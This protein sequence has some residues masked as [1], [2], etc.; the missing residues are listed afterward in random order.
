MFDNIVAYNQGNYS[1]FNDA[2]NTAPNTTTSSGDGFIRRASM[3]SHTWYGILSTL[4]H[5]L[6]ENLTLTAGID[7]RYYKGEHYRRLE[8]LL[9]N[10]SYV[11]R[12]DDNNPDNEIT[13]AS[14]AEFGN[15][16]D[17]SYRDGN[18][19]LNYHNDGL[20]SW[21]GLFGQLEYKNDDMS[22]FVSFNG[23]QQGF[24]N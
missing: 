6:S 9:G 5:K 20:V 3:N 1:G 7:A 11:S 2:P 12:S 19:V 4:D 23:S 18:N 10:T 22:A 17:R 15:F 21:L 16:L 24:K 13:V 8:N 14:P